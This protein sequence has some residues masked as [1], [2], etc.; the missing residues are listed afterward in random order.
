MFKLTIV[1]TETPVTFDRLGKMA[2]ATKEDQLHMLECES[3]RVVSKGSLEFDKILAEIKTELE[4]DPAFKESNHKHTILEA[5]EFY[6]CFII[7]AD[8]D[9][10][11]IDQICV[12]VSEVIYATI[13]GNSE[14][15]TL[16][17][18]GAITVEP[19]RK[20]KCLTYIEDK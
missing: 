13:K 8:K 18:A 3:F 7:T 11:E 15:L 5:Q 14:G 17:H 10:K 20:S 9:L 4:N 19:D 1:S 12:L 2:I 16:V 6:G